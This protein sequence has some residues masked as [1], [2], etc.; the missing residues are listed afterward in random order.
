MQHAPKSMDDGLVLNHGRF[1]QIVMLYSTFWQSKVATE[2]PT[3]VDDV[4]V[5]GNGGFHCN[6]RFQHLVLSNGTWMIV[7]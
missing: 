5:I 6:M 1:N 7:C 4:C 3:F 2:N